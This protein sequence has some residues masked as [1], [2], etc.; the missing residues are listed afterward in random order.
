MKNNKA[1]FIILT[2]AIITLMGVYSFNAAYSFEK[3]TASAGNSAADSTVTKTYT[4]PMHPEVIS[5]KPGQCPKCGMDLELKDNNDKSDV[6]QDG[7]I[8]KGM[9]HKD[10]SGCMHKH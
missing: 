4:C 2:A 9:D 6:K 5:D 1:K 8:D 7:N 10:C 3:N